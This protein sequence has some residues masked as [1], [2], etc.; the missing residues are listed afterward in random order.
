MFFEITYIFINAYED[1]IDGVS[2][3]NPGTKAMDFLID[4][5]YVIITNQ[6][7]FDFIVSQVRSEFN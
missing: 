5:A 2:V 7:P 6:V 3:I 1:Y 4:Y